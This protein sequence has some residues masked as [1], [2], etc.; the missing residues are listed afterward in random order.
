MRR[1]DLKKFATLSCA[2][3]KNNYW[4]QLTVTLFAKQKCDDQIRM[5][6]RE[7][8]QEITVQQLT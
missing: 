7:I 4:P 1:E 6:D 8:L 3:V 5:T 2:N